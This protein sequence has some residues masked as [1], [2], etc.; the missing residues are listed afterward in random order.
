MPYMVVAYAVM[1][2]I[3]MAA[4]RRAGTS[5]Y[6]VMADK[7]M[8][9]MVVA[10]V[11]M[12]YIVMAALRRAGTSSPAPPRTARRTPPRSAPSRRERGDLPLFVAGGY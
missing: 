11:V 4:L 8:P 1:A 2:Y 5:S 7:V 12:A 6:T 3:I 10:Y 9:Y